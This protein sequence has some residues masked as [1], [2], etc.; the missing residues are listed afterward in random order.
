VVAS[1]YG[2][3]REETCGGDSRKGLKKFRL[4]RVHAPEPRK[5]RAGS[6][7]KKVPVLQTMASKVSRT[8][9]QTVKRYPFTEPFF[10]KPIESMTNAERHGPVTPRSAGGWRVRKSRAEEQ[11]RTSLESEGQSVCICETC[12]HVAGANDDCEECSW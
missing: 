3:I 11:T 5:G 4:G 9:V 2:A 1:E 10:K 7:C 8:T 6:R 12:G